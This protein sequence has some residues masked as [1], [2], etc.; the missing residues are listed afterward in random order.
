MDIVLRLQELEDLLPQ[1]K[2][3]ALRAELSA[4][5]NHLLLHDFTTLISILYRVD[6]PE[7]K[8]KKILQENPEL[9]AGDIIAD[10]LLQGQ[11][12]KIA[13]RRSMPPADHPSDDERW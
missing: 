10:L 12:E 4:Y 2:R 1:E 11:E 7:K 8:L 13:T 5:I 9:D 6:V 3:E